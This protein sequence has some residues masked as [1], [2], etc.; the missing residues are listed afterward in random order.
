MLTRLCVC[1]CGLDER[2]VQGFGGE[3]CGRRPL[4]GSQCMWIIARWIF[5]KQYGEE[6]LGWTDLS[7]YRGKWRALVSAVMSPRVS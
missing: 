6:G 2:C 1:V 7:Q 5:K 4:G 3:T